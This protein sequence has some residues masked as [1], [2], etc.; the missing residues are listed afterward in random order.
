[1]LRQSLDPRPPKLHADNNHRPIRE[2]DIFDP[3]KVADARQACVGHQ[4]AEIRKDARNICDAGSP[5]EF[6]NAYYL[7]QGAGST[8]RPEVIL[9]E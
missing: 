8:G 2:L 9:A 5:T 1:V 6:L 7:P 4:P 3:L